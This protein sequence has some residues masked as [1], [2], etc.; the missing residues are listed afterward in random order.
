MAAGLITGRSFGLGVR[1][2][3]QRTGNR[4][5]EFPH[6]VGIDH[7]GLNVTVPEQLL[8]LPNVGSGFEQMGGEAVP[9]AMYAR[10]LCDSG[11]PQG[12]LDCP[13]Q[14]AL[15]RVEAPELAVLPIR[16]DDS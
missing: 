7:G 13:L 5:L 6:D 8:D 10:V 4:R 12:L 3:V 1:Q 16:G 14:V 11:P 9:Q 15:R 2:L